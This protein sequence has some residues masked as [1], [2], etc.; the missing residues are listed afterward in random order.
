[1]DQ[2]TARQGEGRSRSPLRHTVELSL[3]RLFDLA[4]AGT[5]AAAMAPL[6]PAV[7]LILRREFGR[8]PFFLQERVGHK[9]RIFKMVKFRSMR[10]APPGHDPTYWSEEDI[11][12]V[13]PL[14]EFLRDYGLDEL[15][16]VWNILKGEMSIIGPRP[17]LVSS[18]KLYTEEQRKMFEMRP[19]VLNLAVI[20]GRRNIPM[21]RRLEYHVEYVQNWSLAMDLEI[22]LKSLL[23]VLRREGVDENLEHWQD[24]YHQ[25]R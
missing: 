20:R 16:Q 7:M 1:M 4:A 14:G 22:L 10:D 3:K 23:V 25:G 21:G 19:G 17:P 11:K 18:E 8:S 13:T 9:R 5:V 24:P 2:A 6:M 12:R 15:P